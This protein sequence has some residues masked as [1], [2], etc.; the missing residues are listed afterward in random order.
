M[1]DFFAEFR[2]EEIVFRRH[3]TETYESLSAELD[4]RFTVVSLAFGAVRQDLEDI[5]ARLN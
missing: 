5:R 4:A 1:S 2:G 3:M